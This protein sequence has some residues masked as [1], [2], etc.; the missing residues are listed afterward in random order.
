LEEQPTMTG[1]MR[2]L[3]PSLAGATLMVTAVVAQ[4]PK[5]ERR[6]GAT[7]P[8]AAAAAPAKTLLDSVSGEGRVPVKGDAWAT[9]TPKHAYAYTLG[10]GATKQTVLFLTVES[11]AD[12]AWRTERYFE[13]VG[14]WAES[15]KTP[16]V[17]IA[18]DHTGAPEMMLQTDGRGEFRTIGTAV[19]KALF[20][21]SIEINDGTRLRGRLTAG[22]GVCGDRYCD[23]RHDYTFDVTV[24]Q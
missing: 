24:L 5:T 7:A 14:Q 8:S 6:A 3:T 19:T 13:V 11:A 12:L 10:S 22:E 21:A 18:F 9:F 17:L 23:K 20:Q 1:L 15:K 16:Y 2:N 4:L